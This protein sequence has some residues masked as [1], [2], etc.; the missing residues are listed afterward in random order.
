MPSSRVRSLK[1]IVANYFF[2]LRM[3]FSSANLARSPL[4]VKEIST[5]VHVKISPWRM[6]MYLW[7]FNLVCSAVYGINRISEA[8]LKA[9]SFAEKIE[10]QKLNGSLMKEIDVDSESSCQLECVVEER[11]QSYNFGTLKGDSGKFKCQLSDSD[12]FVGFANFIED[13]HFI[14]RGIMVN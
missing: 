8:D 1:E 10:G 12:R 4:K 11:C 7:I 3:Y 2:T 6:N 14:Y 13:E 5:S 9:V